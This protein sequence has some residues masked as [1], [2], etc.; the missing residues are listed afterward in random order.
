MGWKNSLSTEISKRLLNH[1]GTK[2]TKNSKKFWK[3]QS[4]FGLAFLGEL[5]ALGGSK[6]F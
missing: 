2:G 3:T 5:G 6:G 1:Q 4:G